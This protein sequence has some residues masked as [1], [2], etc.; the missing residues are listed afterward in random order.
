[1]NRHLF[2][3]EYVKVDPCGYLIY[4]ID[5]DPQWKAVKHLHWSDPIRNAAFENNLN[6]IAWSMHRACE[7]ER[8]QLLHHRIGNLWLVVG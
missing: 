6:L 3:L 1:M 4:A 8:K 2:Q 5:D 7:H